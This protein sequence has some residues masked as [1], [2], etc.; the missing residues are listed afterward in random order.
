MLILLFNIPTRFICPVIGLPRLQAALTL[1]IVIQPLA[2][3]GPVTWTNVLKS[4]KSPLCTLLLPPPPPPHLIFIHPWF[5]G[6]SL[7]LIW[8][9]LPGHL[10]PGMWRRGGICV[11]VTSLPPS[12]LYVIHIL[13]QP[14]HLIWGLNILD[15]GAILHVD[16]PSHLLFTCKRTMSLSLHVFHSTFSY[17]VHLSLNRIATIARD[18]NLVDFDTWICTTIRCATNFD[19]STIQW[20]IFGHHSTWCCRALYLR[21]GRDMG[22]C[23][24]YA[25]S[26][27]GVGYPHPLPSIAGYV[28]IEHSW[29]WRDSAFL[30]S[31]AQALDLYVKSERKLTVPLL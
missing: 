31:L 30:F 20:N 13:L 11:E 6:M 29:S 18:S 21:T 26:I 9:C 7:D 17:Q 19:P 5:R 3:L 27:T 1:C 24:I 25:F 12:Q 28:R 16:L 2:V 8:P 4:P 14:L 23:L 22:L 10:P 15:V